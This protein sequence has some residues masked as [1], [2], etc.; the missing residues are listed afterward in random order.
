[1][2]GITNIFSNV[3]IPSAG[4]WMIGYSL[5]F[6]NNGGSSLITYF[7][8]YV[9]GSSNYIA[10]SGINTGLTLIGYDIAVSASGMLITSNGST[11]LTVIVSAGITNYSGT[12]QCKIGSNFYIV[13]VG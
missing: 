3:N 4:V 9:S 7:N 10:L 11:N 1:L 6:Y 13:R 5:N 2:S 12:P 8:T